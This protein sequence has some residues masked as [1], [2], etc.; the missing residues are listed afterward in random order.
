M[1]KFIHLFAAL[2]AGYFVVKR[3]YKGEPDEKFEA[4]HLD[5]YPI[6][7]TQTIRVVGWGSALGKSSDRIMSMIWHPENWEVMTEE[8]WRKVL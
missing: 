2:E 7:N 1:K 4:V 3:H 6:P 8:E 5:F